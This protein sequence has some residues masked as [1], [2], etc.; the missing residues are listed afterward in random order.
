M[1]KEVESPSI[2][3]KN[4]KKHNDTFYRLDFITEYNNL[5]DLDFYLPNT[6]FF[7]NFSTFFYFDKY[8]LI[9]CILLS[10]R[11]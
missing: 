1:L 3:K 8:L 11:K 7:L 9:Q 10:T 5:P 4:K 2:K 6:K